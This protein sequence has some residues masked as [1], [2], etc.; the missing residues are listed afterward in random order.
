MGIG[1]IIELLGGLGAFLFGMNYMG[2]GLELAAGPKMKDLL[3]KLTRNRFMG[4]LL[5]TLVTVVIQSSSATTV[6]V[7]GFINAGIM[8]LAQATGVIF[9]ANIG[10][11]ITSVLIALDVSGLAPICICIGAVMMLYSKKKRNRYIGQVVL[12]FGILFQGLHTMSAAMSPLKD[13]PVFQDFIMNAKNPVLGFVVGAVLCAVIQSSSAAVGVLQALAMQGLMPLHFAAFLICGINVGSSTP[14]LLSALNAKNN[15]KRAACIYLIF[16]VIGAVLFIPLVMFTPLTSIIEKL[17]PSSVFQIS[18]FHI[19]FKV[20]TGL[21][22]LPC[23][24]W[25]VKWTYKIIPKQA[26]ESA[27]RLE[28]IDPNM[29]GSPA[30]MALQVGKEV[31]RMSDLVHRN[32]VDASESLIQNDLSAAN[33]IREGEQIIDY[34]ASEITDFLAKVN[35]EELPVSI[36]EYMGCIFHAINDL[37]QIGDHAIKILEQEEKCSDFGQ[38]YSEAAQEELRQ[39]YQLDVELLDETVKRFLNREMTVE[40]WFSI[41]KKERKIIKRV[42]KAQYNHMERLQQKECTFEQ[43]LTFIEALNSYSRIVNHASNIAEVA[44]TD[45]LVAGQREATL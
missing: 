6:M 38:R 24:D 17:V 28:Y 12:G 13:S 42:T 1:S 5:G 36:S 35:A 30:V 7:M 8:D 3:E 31:Q 20:V 39:I 9:G 45:T 11:T 22:L 21:L 33:Q 10:T 34:L 37:E 4:F 14:P 26:H 15:A 40:Q 27:F 43:G 32:L 41:K 18:L 2:E 16:N 19:L 44:G 23:V 29:V 25:V